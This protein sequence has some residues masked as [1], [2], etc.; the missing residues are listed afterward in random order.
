MITFNNVFF[1][2]DEAI[3]VSGQQIAMFYCYLETYIDD[4]HKSATQQVLL[5]VVCKSVK[6]D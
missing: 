1:R 3:L 2:E 4:D 6:E 5:F